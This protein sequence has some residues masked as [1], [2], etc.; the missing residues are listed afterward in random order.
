MAGLNGGVTLALLGV[1]LLGA[2]LLP[3]GAGGECGAASARGAE[4]PWWPWWPASPLQAGRARRCAGGAGCRVGAGTA[5]SRGTEGAGLPGLPSHGARRVRSGAGAVPSWSPSDLDLT[6]TRSPGDEPGANPGEKK[7]ARKPRPGT[8]AV[9]RRALGVFT[10]ITVRARAG[11]PWAG[12]CLW[13]TLCL[14]WA[15]DKAQGN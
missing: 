11:W 5:P 10:W 2:A 12:T 4:W 13:L 9:A 7:S 3:R 15:R 14:A 1:L 6:E 8:A